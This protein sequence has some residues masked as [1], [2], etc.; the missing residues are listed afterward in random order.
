MVKKS[1]KMLSMKRLNEYYIYM[2][3]RNFARKVVENGLKPSSLR[4]KSD[5][6]N[7]NDIINKYYPNRILKKKNKHLYKTCNKN[8][9]YY[10]SPK[11]ERKAK[12][13]GVNVNINSRGDGMDIKQVTINGKDPQCTVSDEPYNLKD[14]QNATEPSDLLQ[15]SKEE[16]D[17][18]KYKNKLHKKMWISLKQNNK[19]EFE[20]YYNILSKYP[21]KDEVSFSI[22]L[23]G[24]L[25]LSDETNIN[26]CFQI[27]KEME[28]NKVH[29]SLIRFNARLLYSYYELTKLNARPNSKQWVK[30]LRTVWFTAALVKARRQR[31]IL[32]KMK[33]INKNKSISL[34]NFNNIFNIHNLPSLYMEN[35]DPLIKRCI[36]ED[37]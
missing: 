2:I 17:I 3:K 11:L 9:R 34:S 32:R 28:I 13:L 31:F 18:Q 1:I 29:C 22:L 10:L 37:T 36:E 6:T 15:I 23:H 7:F 24:K 5:K 26:E 35:R 12:L 33:S 19:K 20:H 16:H 8:E 21:L 27:L 4:I 30:V 25:M 14:V